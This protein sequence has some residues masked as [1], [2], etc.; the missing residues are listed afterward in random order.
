MNHIRQVVQAQSSR[1]SHM[2]KGNPWEYTLKELADPYPKPSPGHVS[3]YHYV[4]GGDTRI[5]DKIAREGLRAR[6]GVFA[7]QNVKHSGGRSD[8][9]KPMVH[10]QAPMEEVKRMSGGALD[11]SAVVPL[12]RNVDPRDILSTHAGWPSPTC[13]ALG[14]KCSAKFRSDMVS[15]VG[16]EFQDIH[17]AYVEAALVQDYDVPRN[18]M[19]DYPDLDPDDPST[20]VRYKRMMLKKMQ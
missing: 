10:F 5:L 16:A 6:A 18:V 7:H 3:L 4:S 2:W 11:G 12:G 13:I 17:R 9:L 20:F 8:N 14:R 19:A 15:F 1:V